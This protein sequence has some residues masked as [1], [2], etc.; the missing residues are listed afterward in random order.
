MRVKKISIEPIN[1]QRNI[2]DIK[3]NEVRNIKIR[4][5][6]LDTDKN[7]RD[8]AIRTIRDTQGLSYSKLAKMFNISVRSVVFALYPEKKAKCYEQY[9]KR[10]AEGRY[11][12]NTEKNREYMRRTL[13][14]RKQLLINQT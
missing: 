13:Q 1:I 2:E 6:A 9:K 5:S 8:L 14:R 12:H 3:D 10:R 11:P 7:A 4:G